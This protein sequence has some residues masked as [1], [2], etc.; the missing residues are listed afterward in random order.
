MLKCKHCDARLSAAPE[1]DHNDWVIPCF[2]C[3]VENIIT[4]TLE[5][6]GYKEAS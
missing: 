5:I 1:K 3:G 4:Q 2:A 6:T